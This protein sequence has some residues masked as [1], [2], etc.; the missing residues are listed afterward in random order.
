VRRVI[1]ERPDSCDICP[2][3]RWW[4]RY[5]GEE[6]LVFVDESFRGFFELTPTGYFGHGAVGVPVREYPR[7]QELVTPV[8]R[9]FIASTGG[10]AKELKH[11]LWKRLD[12]PVRR[13]LALRLRDALERCGGFVAGFYAPVRAAV[14][15]D[16]RTNLLGRAEALPD[17][18][19]ALYA[20]TV[21]ALRG[22]PKGP[23]ESK[24]IGKLLALP[25]LGV[26]HFLGSF[27]GSFRI[28]CDPREKRE[29]RV[30]HASMAQLLSMMKN[31]N[32]ALS[33]A[34]ADLHKFFRGI[35]RGRPSEEDFG[36]QIADI[37]VGEVCAFFAANPEM[38]SFG[39][40]RRIVTQGSVELQTA[41]ARTP[42]G[43]AKTGVLQKLHPGLA[44]RFS[45]PDP[46]GRTV[47]PFFSR[48]FATGILTCYSTTGQPRDICVFEKVIWDQTDA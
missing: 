11:N 48:L 22:Q 18:D 6:W 27:G 3:W 42:L 7:L 29:D 5:Q 37:V 10:E 41:L 40:S 46:E 12:Y 33:D 16:V 24:A 8:V 35:E 17:D 43:L 14:L 23:G 1:L 25:C 44:K 34:P 9:D 28:I 2:G 31:I 26:A 4:Q 47:L 39:A 36:L 45:R 30:V 13:R 15:E 21:K 32:Q 38:M 20:E 19:E